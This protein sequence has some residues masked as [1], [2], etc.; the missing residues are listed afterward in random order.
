MTKELKLV[1]PRHGALTT[2]CVRV[3]KIS[4]DVREF[5]MELIKLMRKEDGMGITA[6]QVGDS[7]AIFIAQVPGD[8]I[9]IFI[10][11]EI[12]WV[13]EDTVRTVEGC[14]SFPD[15]T[16]K[17]Q[18]KRHAIVRALNLKGDTFLVDTR[19]AIYPEKVSILLS[20]C[21]QHEMDHIN[22]KDMRD[23]IF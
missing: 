23:Y 19:D 5:V 22:G 15:K 16:L 11:P 13:G 9:R 4:T 18:R 3:K 1:A 20:I 10:N 12:I 2:P 8:H 14:L 21:M 7:R 17:A 6:N